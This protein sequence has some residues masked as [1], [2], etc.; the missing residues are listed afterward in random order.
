VGNIICPHNIIA[1]AATVGM[2]GQEGKIMAKTI[3]ACLIYSTLG[4]LFAFWL[5]S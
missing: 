1:G 2:T 5:V 3:V 4:G